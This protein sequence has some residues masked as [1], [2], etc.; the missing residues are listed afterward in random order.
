MI[1]RDYIM[2]MIQVLTA[3]IAR[4]LFLKK[5]RDF[6]RALLEI[7]TTGRTLLGVDQT[8]LRHLSPSQL[9]EI[10]GSDFTVAAPKSYVLGILMAEEADIH[11]LMGEQNES[12]QAHMTSLCL[13]IDSLRKSGEPIEP[14]HPVRIDEMILKMEGATLPP[15]VQARVFWYLERTGRFDKAENVLYEI[16]DQDPGFKEEGLG[17]YRRLLQKSDPDLHAGNLPRNEVEEGL[18][19]LQKAYP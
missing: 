9:M 13:L 14:E 15:D 1:E 12:D 2:R 10:F 7:Q 17:F 3:A 16:L 5:A 18:E 8:L 6:P 19:H 11:R 4:V